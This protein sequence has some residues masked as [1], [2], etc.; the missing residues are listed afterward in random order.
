M[1]QQV[2][3]GVH[4]RTAGSVHDHRAHVELLH[5]LAAVATRVSGLDGIDAGD[6][7]GVNL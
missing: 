4:R 3:E 6:G 1:G 5:Q 2:V 7:H